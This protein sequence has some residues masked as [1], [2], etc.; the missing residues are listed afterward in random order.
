MFYAA[1]ET[2]SA[3]GKVLSP[4]VVWAAKSHICGYYGDAD[5]FPEQECNFRMESKWVYG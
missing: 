4:F 2:I 1:L 3:S 5:E